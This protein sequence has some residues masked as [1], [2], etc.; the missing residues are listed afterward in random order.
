[1]KLLMTSVTMKMK[2]WRTTTTTTTKAIMAYNSFS[3]KHH[4]KMSIVHIQIILMLVK[5][6]CLTTLTI[7]IFWT[8]NNNL[9]R[10][11]TSCMLV[12]NFV[13]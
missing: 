1:M 3:N 13:N 9:T 5:S 8:N 4:L 10:T 7:G 11:M 6:K 2:F 12:S